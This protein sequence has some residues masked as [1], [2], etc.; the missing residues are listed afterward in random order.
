M[1]PQQIML[2][3]VSEAGAWIQVI[4][5]DDRRPAAG[6]V[7]CRHHHYMKK[8]SRTIGRRAVN[9][10]MAA[11]SA[12]WFLWLRHK[13]QKSAVSSI[14]PCMHDDNAVH[15]PLRQKLVIAADQF[16]PPHR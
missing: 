9:G 1:C 7:L 12:Y 8:F 13:V 4:D 6:R 14:Y 3:L 5:N 16:Q 10:R 15:V 2:A 11:V